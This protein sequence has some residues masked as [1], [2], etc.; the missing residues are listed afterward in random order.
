MDNPDVS[1]T[2]VYFPLHSGASVLSADGLLASQVDSFAMEESNV[3]LDTPPQWV[4]KLL[5]QKM[6]GQD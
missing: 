3:A 6:L 2:K 5:K 4:V 1:V